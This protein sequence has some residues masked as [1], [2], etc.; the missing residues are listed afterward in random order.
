M[1]FQLAGSIEFKAPMRSVNALE[2]DLSADLLSRCG[3]FVMVILCR[4]RL[5]VAF[6]SISK[7]TGPSPRSPLALMPGNSGDFC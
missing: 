4:I 3:G 6:F 7:S 2:T 5:L 1:L